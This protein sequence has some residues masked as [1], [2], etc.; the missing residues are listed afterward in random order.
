M[1]ICSLSKVLSAIWVCLF[2]LI[3]IAWRSV[4]S[5]LLD[6]WLVV[7]NSLLLAFLLLSLLS[8]S[9]PNEDH[10]NPEHNKQDYRK[11][12]SEQW[13]WGWISQVGFDQSNFLILNIE[14]GVVFPEENVT[15]QPN[16]RSALFLRQRQICAHYI[17][18][19][20]FLA[21]LASDLHWVNKCSETL[22]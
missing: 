12:C 1:Y 4:C 15:Y 3:N 9:E 5:I 10:R 6:K 11:D 8:V 7:K 17:K 21:C 20:Y 13:L 14:D 18:S 16:Q 22:E 19:E 2:T